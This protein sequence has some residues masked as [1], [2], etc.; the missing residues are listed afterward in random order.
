MNAPKIRPSFAGR[1]ILVT[2]ADSGIGRAV[3]HMLLA[4]G[5]ECCALVRDEPEAATLATLLAKKCIHKVDLRNLS[6]VAPATRA[7]LA[8]LGGP[9]D[10]LVCSA[11][12]F[13]HLGALETPWSAG[14]RCSTST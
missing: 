8:S 5:A 12:V 2:G 9:V 7:A 13:E 11:G 4:E 1:R 14:S 3:L 10:G 6:Q